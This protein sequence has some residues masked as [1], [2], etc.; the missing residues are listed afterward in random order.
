[1]RVGAAS[2]M[3]TWGQL[4]P[5]HDRLPPVRANRHTLRVCRH[6]VLW[7][8]SER[9]F[10]RALEALISS[11][12]LCSPSRLHSR[13]LQRS[14]S[15]CGAL[16]LS[17]SLP[18]RACCDFQNAIRRLLDSNSLPLPNQLLT[19]QTWTYLAALLDGKRRF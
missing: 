4:E 14:D 5:N 16:E 1:M 2:H 11:W 7:P 17:Q 8:R 15:Y 13:L 3:A 19:F 9:I 6:P 10:S 12:L 18:R